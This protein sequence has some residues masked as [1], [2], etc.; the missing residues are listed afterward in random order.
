MAVGGGGGGVDMAGCPVSGV[1]VVSVTS[2]CVSAVSY[3]LCD[4]FFHMLLMMHT[5]MFSE[6]MYMLIP[7]W[8]PDSL[9]CLG[10]QSS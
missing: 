1:G 9:S 3:T 10:G 5:I 2:S 8:C 6:H 7:R 4:I